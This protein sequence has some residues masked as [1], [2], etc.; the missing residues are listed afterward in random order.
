[1]NDDF[2]SPILIANLFEASKKIHSIANGK[3]TISKS[4]LETLKESMHDFIFDVLGLMDD[5]TTS[6]GDNKLE[7]A[8]KLLIE[9]RNKARSN[10]DFETSDTIRDQ[11]A[12]AGIQLKDGKDGTTFS[13]N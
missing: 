5:S 2:N 10:K 6:G 3:D 4:D 12:A 7:D 8:V 13:L 11:L 9:L 1:M